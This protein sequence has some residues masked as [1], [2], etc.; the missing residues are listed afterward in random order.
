MAVAKSAGRAA[1][2]APKDQ[3]NQSGQTRKSAPDKPRFTKDE[4]LHAYRERF[5]KDFQIDLVAGV[6]EQV[7]QIGD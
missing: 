1:R 6:A 5:T 3:G 4:E 2:G 7:T